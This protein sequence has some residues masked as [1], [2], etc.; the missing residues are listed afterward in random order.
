MYYDKKIEGGIQIFSS[1]D[2]NQVKDWYGKIPKD[3]QAKVL[4]IRS[5]DDSKFEGRLL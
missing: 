5:K 4:L 1:N 2:E 3:V